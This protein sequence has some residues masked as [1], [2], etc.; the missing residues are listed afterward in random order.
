MEHIVDHIDH[1]CQLAGNSLHAGI[2]SDLDGGFG[3]EESPLDLD[4]IA[5]LQRLPEIF[6]ARGYRDEDVANIMHGNFVRFLR[7]ALP[8]AP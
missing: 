5:D 3:L 4:S 2:C 1:M 7:E 6:K 8:Q